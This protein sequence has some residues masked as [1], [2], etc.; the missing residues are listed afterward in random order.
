MTIGDNEMIFLKLDY[1]NGWLFGISE[2]RVKPE[3]KDLI[4]KYKRECYSVLANHFKP[5]Q[6]LELD[7]FKLPEEKSMRREMSYQVRDYHAKH[8]V[9]TLTELMK[10]FHS[11]YVTMEALA[12]RMSENRVFLNNQGLFRE[13][14]FNSTIDA[15]IAENIIEVDANLITFCEAD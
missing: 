10:L 11:S 15:L 8:V 14:L 12:N 9:K 4:L 1:L 7:K 2:N 3:L 5:N 13:L 6:R